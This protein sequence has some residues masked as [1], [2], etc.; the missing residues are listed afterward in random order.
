M[1]PIQESWETTKCPICALGASECSERHDCRYKELGPATTRL[2]NCKRCTQFVATT[3]ALGDLNSG[4]WFRD[5]HEAIARGIWQYYE[6]TG[7][8]VW[9]VLAEEDITEPNQ[10][11]PEQII[12][13]G[14][15]D[16]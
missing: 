10:K 9:I 6:F 3:A 4:H 2:F 13:Y 12:E 16:K 1:S 5:N 15:S 7:E 8:P 14:E 11:T